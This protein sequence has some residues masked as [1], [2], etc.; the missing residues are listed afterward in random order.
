MGTRDGKESGSLCDDGVTPSGSSQGETGARKPGSWPKLLG[1]LR[2]LGASLGP[3][4]LRPCESLQGPFPA[5][6]VWEGTMSSRPE[7]QGQGRGSGSAPLV[8]TPRS[9]PVSAQSI[10]LRLHIEKKQARW[11][12]ERGGWS[13]PWPRDLSGP[14]FLLWA[15]GRQPVRSATAPRASWDAG[16]NS[17]RLV[18]P[19]CPGGGPLRK[20]VPK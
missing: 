15:V 20:F 5:P 17:C 16:W 2:Q 19:P 3:L 4:S 18:L 10:P 7:P 1:D 12:L 8:V 13:S 14:R 9:S 6:E 11:R